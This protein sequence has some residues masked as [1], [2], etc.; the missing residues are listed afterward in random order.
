[1][2]RDAAC[3]I[4]FASHGRSVPCRGLD[5]RICLEFEGGLP[6]RGLGEQA[7]LRPKGLFGPGFLK[8]TGPDQRAQ[9]PRIKTAHNLIVAWKGAGIGFAVAGEGREQGRK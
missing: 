3:R 8:Q 6:K 7:A 1:M 4:G 5:Q 9:N 2:V